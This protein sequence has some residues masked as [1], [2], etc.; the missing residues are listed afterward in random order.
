[1]AL[2][3][4]DKLYTSTQV[5]DILGVSLRTLYRYMEDV[6]IKSMR[7]ASGRHRFT[8]D[9]ILEFLNAGQITPVSV[10]GDGGAFYSP[11]KPELE[12]FV[13][14]EATEYQRRPSD[15]REI[16]NTEGIVIPEK[17]VDI[18]S[19]NVSPSTSSRWINENY[20]N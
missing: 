12:Q 5:A 4:K 20:E 17:R 19:D 10:S 6:K 3:L 13:R 16:G 7:T 9:Q 2:E 15:T 11:P 14:S 1:M 8:K 18:K